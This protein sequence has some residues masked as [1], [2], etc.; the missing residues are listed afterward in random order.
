M[1]Q[2]IIPIRVNFLIFATLMALL[3]LTVV[4]SSFDLGAIEIPIALSIAVT[5]A[6]LIMMYFMHLRFSTRLTWLFAASSSLWLAI[7]IAFL[8]SD[9]LSRT[10]LS[11][12]VTANGPRQAAVSYFGGIDDLDASNKNHPTALGDSEDAEGTSTDPIGH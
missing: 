1:S 11:P 3:A 6:I 4:V 12:I 7:L 5:K 8:L 10:W 9:F 2:H